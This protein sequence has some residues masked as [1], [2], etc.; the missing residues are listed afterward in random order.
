MANTAQLWKVVALLVP[1][2]RD[3]NCLALLNPAKAQGSTTWPYIEQ[4][5]RGMKMYESLQ[6]TKWFPTCFFQDATRDTKR[7]WGAW[8][9]PVN[10]Y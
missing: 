5:P 4:A 7:E 10:A 1:R 6:V 9:W 8:T 3:F 2:D